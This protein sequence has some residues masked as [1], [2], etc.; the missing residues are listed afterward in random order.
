MVARLASK[1]LALA[2]LIGLALAL[3]PES[4]GGALFFRFCRIV[5]LAALSVNL[6]MCAVTQWRR[7]PGRVLMIHVGILV[8]LAGGLVGHFGYVATVNVHEGGST[9]TAFRWDRQQDRA[10]GFTLDVTRIHREYYPTLVRVGVLVD[11]NPV[12]LCELATGDKRV[13]AGLEIEALAID[14]AI[15]ALTLAVTPPDGLRSV[16]MAT[17]AT[18]AAEDQGKQGIVLQ[19]VAFKTP[20]MKRTWVDLAL[21][22][23][24]APPVIGQAEVNHPFLWQGIR[25]FHTASGADSLGQPYAGI[26]IVKDQGLP[27]VYMG[28]ALFVLGNFLLLIKKMSANRRGHHARHAAL[29]AQTRPSD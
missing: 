9:A 13:C 28:F 25:F 6:T 12:E 27:L 17:T 14:P 20:V 23:E 29:A 11:G 1:R 2:L 16:V 24:G 26:Q 22:T 8:I 19:L 5:L 4:L 15:P 21:A 18:Y 10:L 7:L 3:I